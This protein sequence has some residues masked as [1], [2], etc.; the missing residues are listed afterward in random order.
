[1]ALLHIGNVFHENLLIFQQLEPKDFFCH[2]SYALF[3]TEAVLYF[4]VFLV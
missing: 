4:E 1:M 3:L 2:L